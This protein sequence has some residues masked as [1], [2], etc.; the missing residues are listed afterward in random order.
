MLAALD[1]DDVILCMIT[2]QAK[3]DRYAVPLEAQ[4]FTEG[5]LSVPSNIRPSRLFTASSEI[6]AST[7][8]RVSESKF[9]E[10]IK[11]INYILS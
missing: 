2:S 1:G 9:A 6:V 5:G 7:A 10:T 3:S 11:V 8:G 4:D